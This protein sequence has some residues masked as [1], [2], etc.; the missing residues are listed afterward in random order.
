MAA[1]GGVCCAS[2]HS[3]LK[4]FNNFTS[5]IEICQ[6]WTYCCHD[7]ISMCSLYVHAWLIPGRR[8]S[9]KIIKLICG[10]CNFYDWR[11]KLLFLE[12]I[13]KDPWHFRSQERYF[14][15]IIVPG[16]KSS[17]YFIEEIYV[18]GISA[19]KPRRNLLERRK[20][21]TLLKPTEW[22]YSILLVWAVAVLR[23]GQGCTGP[24]NLAQPPKFFDTVS[25]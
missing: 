5:N 18:G 17:T 4:T 13:T 1:G 6:S 14:D 16:S 21:K 2:H 24:P 22:C 15:V 19:T 20:W 25:Q 11:L 8:L 12:L 7:A 3:L 9:N 10:W 23:L